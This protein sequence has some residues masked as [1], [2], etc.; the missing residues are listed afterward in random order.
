MT[1]WTIHQG[2]VVDNGNMT[3]CSQRIDIWYLGG[4]P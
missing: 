3:L 4:D 1:N 2:H